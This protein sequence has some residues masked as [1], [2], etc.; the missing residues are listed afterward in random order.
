MGEH[1]STASN[2]KISLPN[3]AMPVR[4][5]QG[6]YLSSLWSSRAPLLLLLLLMLLLRIPNAEMCQSHTPPVPT[7][8]PAVN[9]RTRHINLYLLSDYSHC[10]LFKTVGDR[11]LYMKVLTN[12][13]RATF[14]G[15]PHE[16]GL[17]L[18][19]VKIGSLNK[20]EQAQM[21]KTS[22]KGGK[23]DGNSAWFGLMFFVSRN[24]NRFK[25]ATIIVMLTAYAFQDVT[26]TGY[27]TLGGICSKDQVVLVSDEHALYRIEKVVAEHILRVMAVDLNEDL[28]EK[29]VRNKNELPQCGLDMLNAS[30]ARVPQDCFQPRGQEVPQV[31]SLPGDV[32]NLLQL[33]KAMYPHEYYWDIDYCFEH[34]ISGMHR[35]KPVYNCEL[36]CC[37]E[38]DTIHQ[39]LYKTASIQGLRCGVENKV[40]RF[41]ERR[42]YRRRQRRATAISHGHPSRRSVLKFLG[43]V[44]H[45]LGRLFPS[46][47]CGLPRRATDLATAKN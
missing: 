13:V 42:D 5:N 21:Y 7:K 43:N 31:T 19:L 3:V 2:P 40:Q 36:T 17:N 22:L 29:C 27:S 14:S 33:C 24:A 35:F 9:F 26:K 30:L 46:L 12:G 39:T 20:S 4:K 6:I 25:N 23:L 11:H 41:S 47:S 38:K 44:A 45:R 1:R 34:E 28:L 16:L 18:R 10:K 8:P 15:L 32:V 37:T